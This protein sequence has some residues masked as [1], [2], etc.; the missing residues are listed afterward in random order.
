MIGKFYEGND[1]LL[2]D[3]ACRSVGLAAM[4]LM[5]SARALGY[6]SC[7]MIGFEPNQVSE[8]VGLDEDHPPLMLVVIGKGTKPAWSRFGLLNLEELVSVDRFGAH[9]MTGEVDE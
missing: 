8:V 2:R 4:A 6:D 5:L 3:E 9:S 1:Q 7:P